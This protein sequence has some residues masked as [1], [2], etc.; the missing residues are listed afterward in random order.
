MT[1]LEWCREL[2]RFNYEVTL[3]QLYFMR[4]VP[5]QHVRIK[6]SPPL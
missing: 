3:S 6:N 4:L 5:M 1:V 2:P